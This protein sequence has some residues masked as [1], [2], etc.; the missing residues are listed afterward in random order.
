MGS[1]LAVPEVLRSL[2]ANPE[3]VLAEAGFDLKLFDDAENRVSYR[4]QSMMQHCAA[5]TFAAFRTPHLSA[6]PSAFLRVAG[7]VDEDAPT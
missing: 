3:A 7:L 2:G 4:P 1:V 6:Q 5:R